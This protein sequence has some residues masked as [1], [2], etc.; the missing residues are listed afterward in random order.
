MRE[1]EQIVYQINEKE[2]LTARKKAALVKFASEVNYDTT[3]FSL[4]FILACSRDISEESHT[5]VFF[6]YTRHGTEAAYKIIKAFPSILGCS[7]ARTRSIYKFLDSR[8]GQKTTNRTVEIHPTVLGYS[9]AR[10]RSIYEFL[11]SR[12]DAEA[13]NKIVESHPAIFR[14]SLARTISIYNFLDTRHE[15]KATNK[16]VETHPT[17][18]SYSLARTNSIYEFLE[19][20]EEYNKGDE[21][22]LREILIPGEVISQVLPVIN[23]NKK[24]SGKLL[25]GSPLFREHLE[26][27]K[28][29]D[30][31]K[32]E[33]KI[34]IFEKDKFIGVF[35]IVNSKKESNMIATPEFILQPLK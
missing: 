22:K 4:D 25:H 29:F 2:G 19:A 13:T 23:I 31:I 30:D 11:D 27:P 20:V 9:L 10:T 26:N 1:L 5:R 21:K 32:K 7:L 33:E 24:F 34:A 14:C 12:H 6:L 8:H 3:R 18:L 35:S 16:I 28:Q 17:V 15:Q